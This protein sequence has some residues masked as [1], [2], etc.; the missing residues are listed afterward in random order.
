[1]TRKLTQ[2]IRLASGPDEVACT[3]FYLDN[4]EWE[5]L[6]EL[7]ATVLHKTRH[8]VQ[9]DGFTVAV[10]EFDDGVFLAEIDDDNQPSDVVP[11][12]LS[13]IRDVSH[14]ERWT[15][16]NLAESRQRPD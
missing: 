6:S 1:M 9:R 16:A 11:E 5:L 14:D 4:A 13:V 2:K 7:P 8:I 15:G 12:W 10:D 3:N